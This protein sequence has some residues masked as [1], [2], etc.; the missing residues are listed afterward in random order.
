MVE[1]HMNVLHDLHILYRAVHM[2][3]GFFVELSA[4]VARDAK[5]F[6]SAGFAV[7][8]GFYDVFRIAR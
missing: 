7:I 6:D 3:I 5:N 2:I 1:H 4:L 8:R